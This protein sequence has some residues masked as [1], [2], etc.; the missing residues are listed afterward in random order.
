MEAEDDPP[1][2]LVQHAGPT[3][4][5]PVAGERPLVEPQRI[6]GD[7]G[8]RLVE[9]RTT[10]RRE[11][12][13]LLV[14]DVRLGR[15]QV[16]PSRLAPRGRR[17]RPRRGRHRCS[18]H[19]PRAATS[20]SPTRTRRTR[21]RRSG[22]AGFVLLRRRCTRPASTGCRTPARRRSRCRAR[23]GTRPASPS[24]PRGRCR[25]RPRTGTRACARR[26]RPIPGRGTS[27]PTRGH[28]ASVRSQLMQV[29][30]QKSTRTT[31]PRRSAAMS[32][33]ELSHPVAPSKP[34]RRPSEGKGVVPG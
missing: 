12:P 8:A 34:G 28:T 32:G 27:P 21:P 2:G 29:Y 1:I 16:R 5:R 26:R 15:P 14:A 19:R 31:L 10:R 33:G 23:S 30:V 3:L 7:V 4:D 25:C 11:A 9:R 20:G 6:R 18:R 22:A 17:A 24:R 13:P